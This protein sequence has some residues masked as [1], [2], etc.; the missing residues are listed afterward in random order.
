MMMMMI[1]RHTI[2][3]SVKENKHYMMTKNYGGDD[4]D[5]DARLQTFG[6]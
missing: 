2:I 5:D 1:T 4:V 3:V 6:D